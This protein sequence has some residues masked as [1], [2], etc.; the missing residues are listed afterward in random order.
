MQD[1]ESLAKEF[2]NILQ[3]KA[4]SHKYDVDSDNIDKITLVNIVSLIK[5]RANFVTDFWE[6]SSY[7]FESPTVYDPKA[8]KNWTSLSSSYLTKIINI[9][10]NA[11]KLDVEAQIKNWAE[12]EEL[13]LGKVMQP[14]RLA[15]VGSLIGIQVFDIIKIIGKDETINRLERA[16]KILK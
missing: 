14:L 2:A 1:N 5:E 9:L 12:Q 10:K 13:N 7:L 3:K 8:V 15:L 11:P 6:L 16:I 4:I